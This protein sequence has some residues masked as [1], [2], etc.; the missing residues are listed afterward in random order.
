MKN[1]L[2]QYGQIFFND[3][4]IEADIIISGRKIEKIGK[5]LN[6]ENSI[7]KIN[8][9]GLHIFPGG[10]DPHV[11][12]HLPTPAG[13]SADDFESGSQAAIAGGTTSLIDFVTPL[14]GQSIVEALQLRKQEAKNSLCDVKFHVSPVGWTNNTEQDIIQCIQNEGIKSFK[15]YMAYRS[16]IGLS[17]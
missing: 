16:N 7:N 8:C 10:I 6:P 4:L 12:L 14:E 5:E 17:D 13:F 3:K 2:L 11:H 15:V 9:T 1:I